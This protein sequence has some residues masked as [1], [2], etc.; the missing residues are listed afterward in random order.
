LFTGGYFVRVSQ[1]A[2][3]Q[4]RADVVQAIRLLGGSR[5]EV[6]RGISLIDAAAERG[7]PEALERKAL[8]EAV[9]C[10]RQQSWDRALDCLA[11]AAEGGSRRAQNQLRVLARSDDEE[12]VWR[13][14]RSA[15]SIADLIQ[16]PPKRIFSEVPRLRAIEGFAT[17]A[18]CVWLVE[19]AR[20]RLRPA[21]VIIESGSQTTKAGRT[22]RAIEFQLADMDLVVEV[23]RARISAATRLPLPL[24]E[25]SQVLHYAPGQEFRVHHDYFDPDNPGHAEHLKGGQRIATFLVYLNDAYTRGETA[26]P[27]AQ[28]SFRGNVGDALFISNV[29]RSGRPDPMTLHAGTP[30]GSGEKWIFSQWIRDRLPTAA[31][32]AH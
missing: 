27:R 13:A 18:E 23:V 7:D 28:L 8:F 17:P 22:N 31:P 5:D 25:T 1:G 10:A 24:F 16:A 14:L 9:G 4:E 21:T 6:L 19:C 11:L 26:F 30:P 32:H 20:D 12:P 29:E 2:V 3:P 15:I